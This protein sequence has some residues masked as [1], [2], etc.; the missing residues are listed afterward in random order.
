MNIYQELTSIILLLAILICPVRAMGQFLGFGNDSAE[1]TAENLVH[2]YKWG[3]NAGL[4]A[5]EY[6][7]EIIPLIQCELYDCREFNGRNSFWLAEVFGSIDTELSRK[8]LREFYAREEPLPK[9]VGAIGLYKLGEKLE[10]IN[11]DSYLVKTARENREPPVG[12]L[13]LENTDEKELAI[14]ALGYSK[15]DAALRS[16]HDI[17]PQ[18]DSYWL[19]RRICEALARIK[20]PSSIPM[21]RRCLKNSEFS[22]IESAYR[23]SICLGD[24]EATHLAI[25]WLSV[26]AKRKYH[27]EQLIDE[28]QKVTGKWWNGR[29]KKDWQKWWEK[30]GEKWTIPEEFLVDWDKQPKMR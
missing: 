20:N 4:K 22:A 28:L 29:K 16:L 7:D 1:K 12:G 8:A 27:E 24:K 10:P 2:N 17:L 11:D 18:Q 23:A 25:E 6:G 26:D 15:S 5:I 13:G 30:E 21:F 9:L 14:I 19:Q 3:M